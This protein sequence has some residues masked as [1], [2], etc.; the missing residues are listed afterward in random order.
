M[1]TRPI[2]HYN[3][4]KTQNEKKKNKTNLKQKNTYRLTHFRLNIG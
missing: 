4:L 1:N 3:K 2:G